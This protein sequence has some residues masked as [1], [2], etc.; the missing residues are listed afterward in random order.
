MAK[1]R[2]LYVGV[3]QK[4]VWKYQLIKSIAA[5]RLQETYYSSMSPSTLAPKSKSVYGHNSS[6]LMFKTFHGLGLA[7][8]TDCLVPYVPDHYDHLLRP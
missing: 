3:P 8:L 7:Y 5:S 4:I 1:L 6:E 2:L